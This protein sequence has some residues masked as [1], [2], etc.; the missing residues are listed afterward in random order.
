MKISNEQKMKAMQ[1]HPSA[2]EGFTKNYADGW[3]IKSLEL[4]RGECN[5]VFMAE[6]PEWNPDNVGPKMW[7][8]IIRRKIEI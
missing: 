6:Y 1:D 2:Q 4:V 7:F 8:A 5:P 3:E